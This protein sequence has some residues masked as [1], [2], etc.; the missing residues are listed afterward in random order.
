MKVAYIFPPPWETR[1]PS[2]TMALFAG[3]TRFHN[4]DYYGFD[5][6]TDLYNTVSK[7]DKK[8]WDGREAY[9]WASKSED[10]FQKYYDYLDGYIKDII[11]LD[12]S[13]FAIYTQGV[14]KKNVLYVS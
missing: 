12:I 7:N 8:L 14:S 6:N 4:Y 2:Y 3:I 1:H 9:T 5:L 11:N 13:I 10:I